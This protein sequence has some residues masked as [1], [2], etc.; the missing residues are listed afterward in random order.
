[1]SV[2]ENMA[3]ITVNIDLKIERTIV[4]TGSNCEDCPGEIQYDDFLDEVDIF[5]DRR[6]LFTVNYVGSGSVAYG[7]PIVG[8]VCLTDS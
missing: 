2:G 7:K 4:K 8:D 3:P 6:S 5:W 1:M